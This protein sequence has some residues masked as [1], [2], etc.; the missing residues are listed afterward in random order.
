M[1]RPIFGLN[2]SFRT[3]FQ[4]NWPAR[5]IATLSQFLTNKKFSLG[6]AGV[7]FAA[8]SVAAITPQSPGHSTSSKIQ[9]PALQAISDGTA[10]VSG[11]PVDNQ[12]SMDIT[13]TNSSSSTTGQTSKSEVLINGQPMQVEPNST[14]HKSISNNESTVD[15]TVDNKSYSSS[16][17]HSS[18]NSS[19]TIIELESFS[20]SSDEDEDSGRD[21]NRRR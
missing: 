6:V 18:Q 20:N 9:S 19:T 15:I 5:L 13:I 17:S 4:H 7:L 14:K 11:G 21:V 12:H 1:Q 2:H 8:G 16:T 10:A 3:G